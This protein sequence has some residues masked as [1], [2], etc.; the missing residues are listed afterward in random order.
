V[1]D[2]QSI[3][4]FTEAELGFFLVLLF[5]VLWGATAVAKTPPKPPDKP[6]IS[7]DS[8]AR[9]HARIKA[10][11]RELDSLK[12]PIWPSCTSK[13]LA[14]GPLLTVIAIGDGLFRVG[15]D[16]L[17]WVEFEQRTA[18]DRAVALSKQCR[19]EVRFGIRADLSA[20]QSERAR[21]AIGLLNLRIIPGPTVDQ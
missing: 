1:N 7:A 17:T 12:S 20:V 3:L 16:T 18:D 6:G 13:R 2:R 19:H 5:V 8:A 21:S 9:L 14:S 11:Q 4:G 15:T 10:L